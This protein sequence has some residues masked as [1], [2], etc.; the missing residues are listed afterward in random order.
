MNKVT[1]ASENI[2]FPQLRFRAVISLQ[3]Q[4][5]IVTNTESCSRR[6]FMSGYKNKPPLTLSFGS[7]VRLILWPFCGRHKGNFLVA[8][9]LLVKLL[10]IANAVGQ[11]FMLNAILDTDFHA[12][13]IDVIQKS[14]SREEWAPTTRFPRVTFCDFKIRRLGNNIHRYVV[15]CTLPVNLFNERIYLVVWFWLVF[16]AAVTCYSFMEWFYRASFRMERHRYV[17]KHLVLAKKIGP[18]DDTRVLVRFVDKYLQADGVMTL[19]LISKNTDAYTVVDI[20]SHL[21]DNY[22]KELAPMY[23]STRSFEMKAPKNEYV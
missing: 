8:L 15:Q 22:H 20:I 11:L 9:Y 12:Y 2:T 14:F 4:S 13:G 5:C 3:T 6:F 19:K 17:K 1:H 21:Y 10:Y 7:L 23:N 18:E 16:I